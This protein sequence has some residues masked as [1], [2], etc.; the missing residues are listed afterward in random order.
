[1]THRVLFYV[2]HLLGLGHLKRAELLAQAMTSSG[3]DVTVALGGPLLAEVPFAHTRIEPLP[4]ANIAGEDFSTLIDASGRPVDE[5]WKSER[6]AALLDLWR[7]TDPDVVLLELF[8]FGR[9]QFRFELIP[10]LEAVHASPR[11]PRVACS[12]RDV[13][14]QAKR[15][16]R[17]TDAVDIVRRYFDQ[18]LV[19]G[20]PEL[21]PFGRTFS[22]AVE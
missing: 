14:V 21:I 2:Q 16:E 1:M 12:V 8:P 10:L 13:L 15:P 18:V 9:R 19:H 7:R 4:P 20:D 5:G 3:L 17:E 11:R 22:R 6:R